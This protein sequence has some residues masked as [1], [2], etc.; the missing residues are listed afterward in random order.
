MASPAAPEHARKA[1]HCYLT[2]AAHEI[3]HALAEDEGIS[4]SGLIEVLA[5]DF[6]DFPPGVDGG[7]P[8]WTG[9]HGIVRQARR[10]DAQRRRRGGS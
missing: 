6:K 7:H 1:L 5:Q 10:L 8:R 3:W 9:E 2:P 4:L